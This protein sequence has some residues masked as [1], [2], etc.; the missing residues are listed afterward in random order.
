MDS[1]FFDLDPVTGARTILHIDDKRIVAEE[2]QDV[3]SLITDAQARFNGFD[4]R[5]RFGGEMHHVSFIPMNVFFELKK[6]SDGS[7]REFDKLLRAWL[8]DSDNRKLRTR[9]GRV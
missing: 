8:N 6:H 9:P 2:R 7:N 1:R 3:E 5:A 4:E